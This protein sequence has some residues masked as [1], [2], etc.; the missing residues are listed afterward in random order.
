MKAAGKEA[1]V[2]GKQIF[3]PVRAALTGSI[4]G[5]DLDKIMAIL[6]KEKVAGRLAGALAR[7]SS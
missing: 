7:D 5:P 1:G 6:G 2:K 3:I 4:E